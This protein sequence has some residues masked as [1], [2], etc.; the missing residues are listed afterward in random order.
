MYKEKHGRANGWRSGGG[1][2]LKKLDAVPLFPLRGQG[3]GNAIYKKPLANLGKVV[4]NL[5]K[6]TKEQKQTLA[7]NGDK[8]QTK[9]EE[10]VGLI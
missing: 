4:S 1:G 10:G 2:K 8:Q 7:W 3:D 9:D 5:F 6:F